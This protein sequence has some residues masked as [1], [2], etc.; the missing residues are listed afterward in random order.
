MVEVRL[1]LLDRPVPGSLVQHH[2]MVA[3]LP[4]ESAQEPLTYGVC[5]GSSTRRFQCLDP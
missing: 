2:E 4:S 3:T 1:V 5:L